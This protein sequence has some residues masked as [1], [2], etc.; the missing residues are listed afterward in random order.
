MTTNGQ[1][2]YDLKTPHRNGTTPILFEP[3]DFIAKLA[4][5]TPKPRVNLT[6]FRGV[7]APSSRH[8]AQVTPTTRGNKPDNA[9]V[10][11][12]GWGDKSPAQRNEP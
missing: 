2:R 5:L 8:R 9:K 4:A 12:T 10:P 11:D 6:R 7:F 1:V 3:M